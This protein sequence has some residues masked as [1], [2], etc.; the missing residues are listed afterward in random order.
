MYQYLEIFFYQNHNLHQQKNYIIIRQKV[1]QDKMIQKFQDAMA[2][3]PL[4][5]NKSNIRRLNSDNL[6]LCTQ[7]FL[8]KGIDK[9]FWF[10][11]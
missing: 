6:N 4:A 5:L 10:N 7:P 3:C 2:C 9:L 8:E 1:D 11:L